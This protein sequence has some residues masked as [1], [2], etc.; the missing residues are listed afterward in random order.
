MNGIYAIINKINGKMY[1]GQTGNLTNRFYRHKYYLNKK[2]HAS[3]HLQNAWNKYGEEAFEFIILESNMKDDI[4]TK[5]ERHFIKKFKTNNKKFGYNVRIVSDSNRGIKYPPEIVEKNRQAQL[6]RKHT[7]ESRKKMS[8]ARKG[9][10][11]SEEHLKNLSLSHKGKVTWIKG[12]HF[13]PEQLKKLSDSHKGQIPWNR[14]IP[15]TAEANEKNR[16]AHL[17]K[18]PW[19]KGR[20]MGPM[21]QNQKNKIRKGV[22][23]AIKEGHVKGIKKTLDK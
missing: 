9:I 10:K 13:T 20:S 5:R 6:G 12:K 8:E 11:F 7:P 21:S 17:G 1:V 15:H 16:K 22:L 18:V 4:L 23:K 3:P 19:N 14:G 2:Q